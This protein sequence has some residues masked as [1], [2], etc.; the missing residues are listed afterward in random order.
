MKKKSIYNQEVNNVPVLKKLDWQAVCKEIQ[1]KLGQDIFESWIIKLKLV[2]EFQYYLVL[3]SPTRFIRDWVVSRYIDKIL[4]IVRLHKNTISRIDFIIETELK[5]DFNNNIN[6]D[7]NSKKEI[8]K[9]NV[10]FIED[11]F[12]SYS[13]LDP[14]K[15][16]K[17]FI[18]GASNNL[19]YQ[20]SQ[21]VCEQIAHYNPLF[22]YG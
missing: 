14:N 20:A 3:S 7:Q 11:S 16:F 15:N 18:V 4:D 5:N 8:H 22:I 2:E 10:S 13:R 21:K 1:N 9:S 12:I 17:N 19:A 6:L